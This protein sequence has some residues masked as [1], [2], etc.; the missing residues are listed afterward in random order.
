M[1]DKMTKL[2]DTYQTLDNYM[3][4]LFISAQ[5]NNA[6][7][8]AIIAEHMQ[9]WV[10][11]LSD[12]EKRIIVPEVGHVANEMTKIP[13][14]TDMFLIAAVGIISYHASDN[15]LFNN[16]PVERCNGDDSPY[17]EACQ[18]GNLALVAMRDLGV[19]LGA[20]NKK[21]QEQMVKMAI[22]SCSKVS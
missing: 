3:G 15:A 4:V 13:G 20:Q 22:A 16:K 6:P 17:K 21:E 5:N 10:E 9:E 18:S 14:A 11:N 1:E 12:R 8:T 2:Q 19:S 7:Q